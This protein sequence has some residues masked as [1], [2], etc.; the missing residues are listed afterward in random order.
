MAEGV[1]LSHAAQMAYRFV[2]KH[3]QDIP[4]IISGWGGDCWMHCSDYYIGLDKTLPKDVIFAAQDNLFVESEP[5][6]A[7]AYGQL[8]PER[9]R[10]PIPWWDNDSYSLWDP[11][12]TTRHFV[13]VCRDV[14]AKKCQGMLAIHWLTRE[15]EEVAAFQSRFAWNP[16]LTYEGFCDSFAERC[17][18]KPWAARMSKIHRDLESLGP[19]WTGAYGD[20]DIRPVTWNTKD[21]TGKKENRQKLADI[22]RQLVT[23][24]EE[25]VAQKRREGIER[26]EWLL[27][28]ID[29]LTRYD[30]ACL[31]MAADGPFGTL[32]KE[33]EAAQAK[34]DFA[35]A[36]R[37]AGAARDIMLH[38]GFREAIQTY[39]KK[40]SAMSEFGQFASIQIKTYGFYL[41]LWERVKKILGPVPD[42]MAGPAVPRDTPPLLVGKMPG[43]VIDPSQSFSVS[44]VAV[45]G[46]PNAACTLNYRTVGGRAWKRL[47]MRATFRRTY[48]AAVPAADLQG[49]AMEWYVEAVDQAGRAA[50]WPKGYPNVIWSAAISPGQ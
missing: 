30:D 32:L 16:G 31:K 28:T 8:P 10:W 3:R 37:K 48:S 40:M 49:C 43:S 1:R 50:H 46:Q 27:T 34:G 9:Q 2:K 18:G 45:S 21:H 47:P 42:D 17:Y 13:P 15:V 44:V 25:M 33:A 29:W 20:S 39:P 7:K 6:V 23:I 22:R 19:R 36:K 14:L 41:A 11:Q 4:V 35:V 5:R 26:V 38:S 12:C 24:R